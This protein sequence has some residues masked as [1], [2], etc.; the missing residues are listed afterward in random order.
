MLGSVDGTGETVWGDVN[1]EGRGR[2][3][4]IAGSWWV[5]QQ[6]AQL[7]VGKS[8]P[9]CKSHTGSAVRDAGNRSGDGLVTYVTV[10]LCMLGVGRG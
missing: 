9:V 2:L 1:W 4:V 8:G 5:A 3:L 7:R 6:L 10:F